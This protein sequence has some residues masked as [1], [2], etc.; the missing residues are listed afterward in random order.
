MKICYNGR[1]T[2]LFGFCFDIF[3]RKVVRL[4]QN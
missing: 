2:V 4:W 3:F 1:A